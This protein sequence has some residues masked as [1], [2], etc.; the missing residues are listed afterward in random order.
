MVQ[1]KHIPFFIN[2]C[3]KLSASVR[4]LTSHIPCAATE[5]LMLMWLQWRCCQTL[6]HNFEGT[7]QF[8]T[9]S[10]R[11]IKRLIV[12]IPNMWFGNVACVC[13]RVCALYIGCW[14]FNSYSL[15]PFELN[16]VP[17]HDFTPSASWRSRIRISSRARLYMCV[18]HHCQWSCTS[19]LWIPPTVCVCVRVRSCFY[20]CQ[21]PRSFGMLL[22]A[23]SLAEKGV[24]VHGF[25]DIEQRREFRRNF[26]K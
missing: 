23:G 25:S 5:I 21:K 6:A 9:G 2:T 13:V 14:R 15:A 8:N 19:W 17:E 11:K 26:P 10:Y 22:L 24:K 16:T 7:K 4:G 1:N 12:L 20:H 3:C 18:L